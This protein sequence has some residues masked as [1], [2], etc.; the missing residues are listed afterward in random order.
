[1]ATE[2]QKKADKKYKANL[3][4]FTIDFKQSERELYEY[5]ANKTN[6]QRYIKDLIAA[7]YND[8][9]T[10]KVAYFNEH[11]KTE[12]IF[13]KGSEEDCEIYISNQISEGKNIYPIEDY[14]I[15]KL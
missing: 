2:A 5:F 8:T 13:F 6:K 15:L 7:D 14:E 9:A 1:M 3:K 10:H 12:I 4:R 11:L